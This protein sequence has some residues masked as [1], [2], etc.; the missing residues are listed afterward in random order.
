MH[1]QNLLQL[2]QKYQSSYSE[3]QKFKTEIINFVQKNPDCFARS[4]A[5]GH[6]TASCWI[7]NRDASQ[8]LLLHHKK[9]DS[10]FQLGGHC[11]GDSDALAVAIKEAQEESGILGIVPVS[12]EIFDIDIHLIPANPKEAA[13]YHYDIRFLLQVNSDE[14]VVQ[15]KESKELRW[16]GKNSAELPTSNPSVIRMFNKWI[17]FVF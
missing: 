9:L 6:V 5:E 16:I 8:A 1:R 3:E 7:L 13:H 17:D 14:S 12:G 15:N 11:D 2:L 4:L 10:W